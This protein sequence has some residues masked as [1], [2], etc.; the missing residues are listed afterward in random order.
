[1]SPAPLPGPP[2]PWSRPR[3]GHADLAGGLKL[4]RHDLGDVLER[5]SARE[6]ASRTAVGAVCRKLLG[7]VGID[8]FAHAV[9]IG[10]VE[11]TVSPG[12]PPDELRAPAPATDLS[13]ADPPSEPRTQHSIRQ[14]PPASH[15]LGGP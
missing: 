11:A 4:G 6:T 1:M 9:A 7:A 12:T 10:P 2:E 13:C 5:A 3:P 14:A 8:V 15:T